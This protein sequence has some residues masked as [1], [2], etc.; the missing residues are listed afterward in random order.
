MYEY[1]TNNAI[2]LQKM[3]QEENYRIKVSKKEEQGEEEEEPLKDLN[4][5]GGGK[6]EEKRGRR[7]VPSKPWTTYLTKLP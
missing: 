6:V 7:M 3:M 1:C 2:I 5:H 4:K